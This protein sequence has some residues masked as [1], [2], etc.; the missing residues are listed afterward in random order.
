MRFAFLLLFVLTQLATAQTKVY[1]SPK[2]GCT[3]A[4]VTELGRAKSS[5]FVASFT[6]TSTEIAK[7]LIDAKKRGVRVSAI[8]DSSNET[9]KYS[10]AT[11]LQNAGIPPLMDHKHPI[12]HN[13]FM[14]IDGAT[15]ITGSF[16]FT[17]AAETSNA[18][19]LLVIPDAKLCGQYLVN[20]QEHSKH[21]ER[22]ERKEAKANS[23]TKK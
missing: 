1:F 3:E 19:N 2:G 5:V 6:F 13:K 10:A 23:R 4:I 21:C 20:W 7:A 11:F 18:E 14:V 22:Y 9:E 17:K 16:N 15:L 8:L 12:F